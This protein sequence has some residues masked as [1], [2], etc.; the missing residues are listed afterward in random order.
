[1][2]A[3]L[4]LASCGQSPVLARPDAAT[5]TNA[6]A[7]LADLYSRARGS[8]AE[9]SAGAY[10]VYRLYQDGVRTCMNAAGWKYTPP[11]F[12][13]EWAGWESDAGT[14]DTKWLSPLMLTPVTRRAQGLSLAQRAQAKQGTQAGPSMALSPAD[15]RRYSS[16]LNS[17]ANPNTGYQDAYHPAEAEQLA[18][19]LET[20][21]GKVDRELSSY[22]VAYRACMRA[23]G[24]NVPDHREELFS[25]VEKAVPADPQD[26]LAP[27]EPDT[28]QW[29]RAKAVEAPLAAADVKCRRPIRDQGYAL[30]APRISQFGRD[31]ATGRRGGLRPSLPGTPG[32]RPG[33]LGHSPEPH[34]V[35][36]RRTFLDRHARGPFKISRIT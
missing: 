27:G 19:A 1:M 12:I 29:S 17:C 18:S 2:A 33:A 5:V 21:V 20:M 11:P 22:A 4:G 36:R 9:R 23:A 10:V 6:E 7:R 3:L 24:F 13:D 25:E 34:A 32:A 14:G 30:L 31:H 35:S 15:R 26:I 8:R 16:A 28:T